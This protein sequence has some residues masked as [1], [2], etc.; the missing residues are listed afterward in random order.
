[1]KMSAEEII[2]AATINGAYALYRQYVSGSLEKGKQS[3]IL[4]FDFPS[5]K[6]LIYHFGVNLL[7]VA[8][9]KGN[10]IVNEL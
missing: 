1:M 7:Q 4:L 5:Y 3:D 9:K 10:F 2:N 8:V 6:D